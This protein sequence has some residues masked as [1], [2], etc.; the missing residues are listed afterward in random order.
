LWFIILE[1]LQDYASAALLLLRLHQWLAARLGLET[2]AN[3][4]L[5]RLLRSL[6]SLCDDNFS[7]GAL[8][9]PGRRPTERFIPLRT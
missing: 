1:R 3:G 6:V 4:Y 9:R 5:A 8:S 7:A 2:S